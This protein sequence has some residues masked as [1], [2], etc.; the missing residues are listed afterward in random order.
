MEIAMTG[1]IDTAGSIAVTD[2]GI[3]Q[4]SGSIITALTTGPIT[5]TT[6]NL[7]AV[8][9]ITIAEE[10]IQAT[11]ISATI[12]RAM[13]E[14]ITMATIKDTVGISRITTITE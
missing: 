12:S 3:A 1:A 11:A 4:D 7:T 2:S 14:G 8:T 13:T 10:S 6:K 9:T 5:I